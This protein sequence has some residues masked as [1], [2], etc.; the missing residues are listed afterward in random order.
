M[1]QKSN[2]FFLSVLFL[3][4]LHAHSSAGSLIELPKELLSRIAAYS[5]PFFSIHNQEDTHT[6]R[7]NICLTP[8]E[9]LGIVRKSNLNRLCKALYL[10][11]KEETFE[12]QCI[13]FMHE[14]HL[15]PCIDYF[16]EL[17][18]A[19]ALREL[20]NST[21]NLLKKTLSIAANLRG[22]STIASHQH[23]KY[24]MQSILAP[25]DALILSFDGE[26]SDS[27]IFHLDL[28]TINDI[29]SLMYNCNQEIFYN[30]AHGCRPGVTYHYKKSFDTPPHNNTTYTDQR[31][32]TRTHLYKMLYPNGLGQYIYKY[33]SLPHWNYDCQA[34]DLPSI[35]IWTA[36][37]KK[38]NYSMISK[39][40]FLS[41][42]QNSL[43]RLSTSNNELQKCFFKYRMFLGILFL[44][45][46]KRLLLV[47]FASQTIIYSSIALLIGCMLDNV[48]HFT[49][50]R[51]CIALFF[52][53]IISA[54]AELLF[55]LKAIEIDSKAV[56][57]I[58]KTVRKIE[59]NIYKR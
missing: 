23:F 31:L 39:S 51:A 14:I 36:F 48:T 41:L 52:S 25:L 30:L 34:F 20:P 1:N 22:I 6:V 55:I 21:E 15:R 28:L 40:F 47:S 33:I 18:I 43:A 42:Y 11:S 37:L 27:T 2:S 35:H 45:K 49:L 13:D 9:T 26:Y 19:P 12:R 7:S 17:C 10:L 53:T 38:H 4:L 46:Y 32:E 59:K 58:V 57:K 5:L 29:Y 16:P 56:S 50:G 44:K 3:L 54:S 24:Y 8:H